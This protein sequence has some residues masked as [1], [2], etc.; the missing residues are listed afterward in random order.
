MKYTTEEALSEIMNR[1]DRIIVR[2]N[3]FEC[4]IL[5]VVVGI[6]SVM[7]ISMFILLK[8][9]PAETSSGTVYG[10]FLLGKE[11][12]GYMIVALLAFVLGMAVVMLCQKYRRMKDSSSKKKNEEI[13]GLNDDNS[14]LNDE[15]KDAMF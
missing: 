3:R 15:R 4:R 13:A 7:L 9:D 10:A 5:S 8:D 6:L 2:R 11:A 14:G 1:K 12:G